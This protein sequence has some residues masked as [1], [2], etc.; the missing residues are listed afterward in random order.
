[1]D[2]KNSLHASN[3]FLFTSGN[4]SASKLIVKETKTHFDA[5]IIFK[6]V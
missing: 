2:S 5:S 4:K 6:V 3:Y 1:M